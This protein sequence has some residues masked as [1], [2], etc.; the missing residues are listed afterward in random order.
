[1]PHLDGLEAT[2]QLRAM[3]GFADTVIFI[4]SASVF[5]EQKQYAMSVGGNAFLNKPLDLDEMLAAMTKHS[6]ILW[7]E[8][9]ARQSSTVPSNTLVP[10]SPE[11]LAT[12]RE[13]L[14]R[15]EVLPAKKLLE[16]IQEPAWTKFRDE[17]LKLVKQFK[18]KELKAF[19]NG[20][21]V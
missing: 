13:M 3:A 17:A 12:L 7:I 10:P 4:L 8:K 9:V 21:G 16:T 11:I 2:R 18:M 6:H 20:F 14:R 5:Q 15:G 1:M 19:V